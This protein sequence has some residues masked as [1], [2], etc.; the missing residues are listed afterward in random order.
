MR[1]P[2]YLFA[3]FCDFSKL[4]GIFGSKDA[5]L[6]NT[7]R[8]IVPAYLRPQTSLRQLGN[9]KFLKEPRSYYADG[10]RA[11]CLPEAGTAGI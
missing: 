8:I 10:A 11:N 7:P 9:L 6:K 1:N 5:C 3:Y 4:D 2:N